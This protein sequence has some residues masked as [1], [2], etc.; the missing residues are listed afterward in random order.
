M[1][2]VHQHTRVDD[3]HKRFAA[4]VRSYAISKLISRRRDGAEGIHRHAQAHR[5]NT[6]THTDARRHADTEAH[7]QTNAR[8]T[9]TEIQTQAQQR[10]GQAYTATYKNLKTP[11]MTKNVNLP[12]ECTLQD[13]GRVP[14]RSI[15]RAVSWLTVKNRLKSPSRNS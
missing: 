12:P 13:K 1:S 6:R 9:H 14:R 4:R 8:T 2:G 3:R 15:T 7:T 5:N 10:Q 11:L